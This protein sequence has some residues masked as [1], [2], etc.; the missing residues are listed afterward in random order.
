[1]IMKDKGLDGWLL[2]LYGVGV[3]RDIFLIKGTENN[4]ETQNEGCAWT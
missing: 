1:M 4:Q 3:S 2:W